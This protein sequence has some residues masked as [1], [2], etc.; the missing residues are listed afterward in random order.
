MSDFLDR[1]KDEKYE[2]DERADKLD[3]F[4]QSSKSKDIDPIQ[5][6]LLMVQHSIMLAYSTVLQERLDH[7]NK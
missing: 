6:S 3:N 7:L 4:L 5:L 2:L 1:L